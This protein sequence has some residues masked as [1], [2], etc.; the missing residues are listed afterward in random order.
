MKLQGRVRERVIALRLTVIAEADHERAHIAAFLLTTK[1]IP[2]FNRAK[3][4]VAILATI[5]MTAATVSFARE[6]SEGPRGEGPGHKL[7]DTRSDTVRDGTR[8]RVER[9]GQIG[10]TVII[11][12][13]ASEGPRGEGPGHKVIDPIVVAREA[14][15]GPRGEGPGHK[16]MDP[17]V[18][19]RE[20]SEGPRG[21]GPG[22]KFIRQERLLG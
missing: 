14:S 2:M 6:A 3:V 8:A 13:E 5:G 20:A 9:N 22:H 1:E 15:E 12:R 4:V 19:A 17:I 7:L 18:V 10:N 11:A 16:V 21:E